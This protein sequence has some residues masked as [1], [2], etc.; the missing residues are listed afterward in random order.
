MRQCN[1]EISLYYTYNE[2]YYSALKH[3]TDIQ[4]CVVFLKIDFWLF[5]FKA[6]I[7]T[8]CWL[9]RDKCLIQAI[10]VIYILIFEHSF[11]NI[12]ADNHINIIIQ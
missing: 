5:C 7:K 11:R 10:F 6:I 8:K 9:K 4:L 12:N 1:I 3:N 2:R